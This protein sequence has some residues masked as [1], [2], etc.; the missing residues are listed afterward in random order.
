MAVKIRLQRLGR[1]NRPFYR[2]VA[3][4]ESVRRNGKALEIL[5]TYDPQVQP[6][7]LIVMK[8][9]IDSWKKKGAT[10]TDSIR[11]LLNW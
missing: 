1:K 5:G 6:P 9:K 10:P 4:D 7:K 2:I 3:A 8:E 11:K